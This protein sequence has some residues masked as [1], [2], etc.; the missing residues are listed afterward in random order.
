M[1][2]GNPCLPSGTDSHQT[3]Q[4]Q[5]APTHYHSLWAPGAQPHPSPPPPRTYVFLEAFPCISTPEGSFSLD[6]EKRQAES[7]VNERNQKASVFRPLGLSGAGSEE[8]G[9]GA[10]WGLGCLFHIS[11]STKVTSKLTK[12]TSL[13]L[14]TTPLEDSIIPILQIRKLRHRQALD[15]PIVSHPIRSNE[16]HGGVK[17]CSQVLGLQAHYS[18]P[19]IARDLSVASL[20]FP[21][22]GPTRLLPFLFPLC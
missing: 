5:T 7:G 12:S 14:A 3:R 13:H 6:M 1:E 2:P 21:A 19:G 11:F 22:A 4:V 20:G 16:K 9:R 18:T 17:I 15:S 10:S 8:V